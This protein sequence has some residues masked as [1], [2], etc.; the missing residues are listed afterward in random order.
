MGRPAWWRWARIWCW[1]PVRGRQASSV[2][3]APSGARR[4]SSTSNSVAEGSPAA[5]TCMRT[6]TADAPVSASGASTVKR[7]ER[8]R[9]ER[10]REVG[11][12][13]ARVGEVRFR[14]GRHSGAEPQASSPEV[15]RS[16]R[17]AGSTLRSGK[18]SAR[19]RGEGVRR[20]AGG[21]VDRQAGRLV[22]HQQRAVVVD[23]AELERR[24]GL[25]LLVAHQREGEAR[26]HPRGR[27]EPPAAL[28]LEP[29]LR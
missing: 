12:R 25:R 11:L 24:L 3:A 19:Q 16:S 7:P 2:T 21:R 8:R 26:H 20:V 18:R 23:H 14:P 9:A 15:S 22:H 5:S 28:G 4:R 27:L 10:E 6:R 29:V 17:W 13:D 1:R